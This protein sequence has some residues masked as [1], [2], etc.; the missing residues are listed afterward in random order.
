MPAE[1]ILA[2]GPASDMSRARALIGGS[3][4]EVAIADEGCG[5]RA[6]VE[7]IES[8]GAEAVIPGPKDRAEPRA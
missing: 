3:A 7:A 2:P 5:S 1:L 8:R 4:V 6:A